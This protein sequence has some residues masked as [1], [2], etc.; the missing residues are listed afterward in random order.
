MNAETTDGASSKQITN[1]PTL[2]TFFKTPDKVNENL[3]TAE[4]EIKSKHT[5]YESP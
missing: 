5:T 3:S 2:A 1:S 4:E